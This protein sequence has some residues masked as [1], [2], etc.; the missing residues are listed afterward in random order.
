MSK[1]PVIFKM[2]GTDTDDLEMTISAGV[3]GE[4]LLWAMTY[5]FLAVEESQENK[6]TTAELLANIGGRLKWLKGEPQ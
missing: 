3:D 5:M 1:K 2:L 4:L 6:V